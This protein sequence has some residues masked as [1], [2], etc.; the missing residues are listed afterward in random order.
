MSHLG[1]LGFS[2]ASLVK[3]LSLKQLSST[4]PNVPEKKRPRKDSHSKSRK[5]ARVVNN[6]ETILRAQKHEWIVGID[7]SLT[8]P[9]LCRLCPR[10]R[11]IHLYA[12]RNRIKEQNTLTLIRTPG[13]VFDGWVLQTTVLEEWPE[14]TYQFSLPRMERFVTRVQTLT[15][16]IGTEKTIVG[17][18]NYA[19]AA[20]ATRGDCILKELGGILRC[21]LCK[22]G[23]EI[24]EIVPS[25]VKNLFCQKGS[26][27]KKDMY[28]A[29]VNQYKLPDIAS[30]IMS[31]QKR[32][33]SHP[34][35][36]MVDAFAVAV[37]VMMKE[38]LLDLARSQLER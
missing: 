3:S 36:D 16:L 10:L 7:M 25:Q 20:N 26:A 15:G 19:F 6:L 22:L 28:A 12:F 27:T 14:N 33:E 23:H 2:T 1:A 4:N 30:L 38:N 17:I 24:V 11:M 31:N 29:F 37:S 13:S 8:N 34:V 5:K 18:E 32:V 9:G 21:E 35:E